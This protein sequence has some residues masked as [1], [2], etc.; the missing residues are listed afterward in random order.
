MKK[1]YSLQ[2]EQK[3][4]AMRHSLEKI[5]NEIQLGY[6]FNSAVRAIAKVVLNV[7]FKLDEIETRIDDLESR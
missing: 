3:N 4:K 1:S 2:V 7:L 6:A 5:S